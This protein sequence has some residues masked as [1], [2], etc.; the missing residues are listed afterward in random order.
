[1][2]NVQAAPKK[3]SRQITKAVLLTGA[4]VALLTAGGATFATWSDTATIN[5]TRISTGEL[6]L[7][8]NSDAKWKNVQ[9]TN[10]T[11]TI[12]A[13]DIVPGD[14]LSF[15]QT[16]TLNADGDL[17]NGT[18]S[19]PLDNA[20]VTGGDQALA[21]ELAQISTFTVNGKEFDPVAGMPVTE[22]NDGDTVTVKL[23]FDFT[24]AD[25]SVTAETLQN[26]FVDF[27]ALE[28]K[29]AQ[30]AIPTTN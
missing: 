28:V 12:G 27:G 13:Y 8:A 9:G 15:T 20:P 18:L 30:G 26:T 11:S 16:V 22:A 17:L 29:V 3:N 21:D 14:K 25:G 1:M 19:V 5:G 23:E 2:S 10:I 24:D 6:N 7:V 4:G